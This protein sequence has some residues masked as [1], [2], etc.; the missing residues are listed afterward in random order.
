MALRDYLTGEI[1]QDHADGL[2]DRREALRRLGMMGVSAAAAAT[3]L[4]GCERPDRPGH[5]HGPGSTPPGT[6]VPGIET[7]VPGEAVRFPGF[8]GELIGSWAAP[9]KRTRGAVLVVHENRGLTPH[10]KE[11]V[12]RFAGVGYGA[13]VVDLL[14]PEGGTDSLTDPAQAPTLLAAAPVERLQGD[15]KAGLTELERRLPHE[16][17]GAVGFCFGGGMVWQLL[18]GGEQ[19]LAAAAPFYGPV[20]DPADFSPARAAVLGVFA[21]LDARVNAGRERAEAAL[22]AAGLRHRINTYAGA[23][24]A[25]FNDT[26]ARYNAVAANQAWSDLLDW[27]DRY[28]H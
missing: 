13:L 9:R 10:F 24:H 17:L 25:F 5:G 28:L 12:G 3:L 4:A 26:G 7:A 27:F 8:S 19:R 6:G 11:L 16:R 2:L 21:E 1:A 18:Q 15:L 20:P 23:D 22:T 14:S